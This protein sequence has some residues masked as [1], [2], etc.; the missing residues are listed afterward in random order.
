MI[1]GALDVDGTFDGTI[2]F[3]VKVHV[4][5]FPALSSVVMVIK[6]PSL[7]THLALPLHLKNKSNMNNNTTSI[8]TADVKESRYIY[9]THFVSNAKK[10]V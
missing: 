4:A 8:D 6:V 7:A 9:P 1:D 10:V 2:T 5:D 3:T